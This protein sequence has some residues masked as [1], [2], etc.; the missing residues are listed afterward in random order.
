MTHWAFDYIGKPWKVAAD[1]P[2]AFDCWGLVVEIHRRFFN[3]K[4]D[5]IPVEENNIK[6]LIRTIDAH[7]ERRRWDVVNSPREGDI[8]LMRQ[9]RH[10]IHVGVWLDVDGGGMLHCA[11]N[12][13]VIFQTLHN[14]QLCGWQIENFYRYK[15]QT[16][17]NDC[18]AEQSV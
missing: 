14:L 16:N 12:C 3:R 10:P 9:S 13:G 2:D 7:P 5:I 17:G 11:Q 1:G 18:G 8:A 4:L 6:A 15:E